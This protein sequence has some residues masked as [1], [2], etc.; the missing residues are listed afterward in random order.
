MTTKDIIKELEKSGTKIA[1]EK[2][3]DAIKRSNDKEYQFTKDGSSEFAIIKL[4]V[5]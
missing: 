5:N 2:L 1:K 4:K 3:L